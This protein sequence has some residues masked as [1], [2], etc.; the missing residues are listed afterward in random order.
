VSRKSLGAS[1][2]RLRDTIMGFS[3]G[4][5][6]VAVVAIAAVVIGGFFFSRWAGTPT[7]APL[8]TDLSSEDASAIVEKL[9]ES[10]VRYELGGD[11]NAIS[12]PKED[13]Y[14]QRLAMSGE[15]LPA[16]DSTGYA[17]LD[18]SGLTTSEFQQQTQF[19][20]ALESE[21]GRTI[22]AIN[23]IET[24]VVHIASPAKSVFVTEEEK[25]T[26]GVLIET[27]T[28]AKISSQ[29]VKSIVHMVASSVEGL[30]PEE[31]SVTDQTGMVLAAPG[32]DGTIAGGN[33]EREQA[34]IAYQD[35]VNASVEQMLQK[36]V[37]A[38]NAV[39]KVTADLDFSRSSTTT[40]SF[41]DPLTLP[42]IAET[43]RTEDMTGGSPAVGGVLGPENTEG[44]ATVTGPGSTFKSSETTRNN[45]LGKVSAETKTAPGAVRKLSVAVLLDTQAAGTVDIDTVRSLVAGAVGIDEGRGDVLAVDRLAFDQS[46][47]ESAAKEL[48]QSREDAERAQMFSLIRTAGLVLL[49]IVCLIVGLR[50]ARKPKNGELDAGERAALEEMRERL[51]LQAEMMREMEANGPS[52]TALEAGA[53]PRAI[54]GPSEHELVRQDVRELVEQ[55]PDEVAA[56]LRSWLGDRRT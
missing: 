29:Q 55:Q 49:V 5:K 51:E 1:A 18:Q 32:E 36:V 26:A 46:S 44:G 10:G 23:G 40:D 37:G 22:E 21:L 31:I 11:G 35:R 3:P 42:P 7:M 20:R 48:T 47:A 39:V 14:A 45:A 53:G 56:L 6:L 9:A 17:A 54:A 15:G 8:Y 16:G 41:I 50:F 38:G 52:S 13:V 43:T 27:K 24:A 2:G 28:G 34:T 19:Q 30:S 33:S 12:V 4:Q 25:T